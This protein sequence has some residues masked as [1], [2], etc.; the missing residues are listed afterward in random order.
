MVVFP[1]IATVETIIVQVCN[2]ALNTWL[3]SF[4]LLLGGFIQE[5]FFFLVNIY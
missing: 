4:V 2:N 5:S 3:I 1:T